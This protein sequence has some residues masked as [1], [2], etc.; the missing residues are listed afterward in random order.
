MKTFL[1]SS[2]LAIAL[3]MGLSA[4]AVEV[5][6]SVQ[7]V[8]RPTRFER[9]HRVM[10]NLCEIAPRNS[11]CGVQVYKVNFSAPG[12]LNW[13]KAVRKSLQSEYIHSL[14]VGKVLKNQVDVTEAFK[15]VAGAAGIERTDLPFLNAWADILKALKGDVFGQSVSQVYA[16]RL[17]GSFSL[18]HEFVAFVDHQNQELILLR[19]GYS[20]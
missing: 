16:G 17:S 13:E 12:N 2:T 7:A 6:V 18:E 3:V 5:V 15:D 1:K 10:Q 9:M 8:A 20:E 14:V 4:Q 11:D 19:A